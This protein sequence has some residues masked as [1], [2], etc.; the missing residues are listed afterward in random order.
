[1]ETSGITIQELDKK[2]LY[3]VEPLWR[4]LNTLHKNKSV[5][6][7]DDFPQ[8]DDQNWRCHVDLQR[9]EARIQTSRTPLPA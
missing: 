1:M 2:D 9:E 6:F 5:H 4:E 8:A 3:L 7:R